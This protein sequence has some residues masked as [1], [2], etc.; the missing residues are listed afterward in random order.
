VKKNTPNP[1]RYFRFFCAFMLVFIMFP[2]LTSAASTG[3]TVFTPVNTDSY[4]S[5]S[6]SLN[7]PADKLPKESAV[8]TIKARDVDEERGEHDFVNVNGIRVGRLSG[9]NEQDSTTSFVID[10]TLIKAGINQIVIN[11]TDYGVPRNNFWNLKVYWGQLLLDGGAAEKADFSQLKIEN[12]DKNGAIVNV[13]VLAEV[14]AKQSGSYTIESNLIDPNGNNVG[15]KNT[16][17]S[18]TQG[19]TKVARPV[20]TYPLSAGSGIYTVNI[21]LFDISTGQQQSAQFIKFEH[22]QNFGPVTDKVA[23]TILFVTSSTPNGTYAKDESIIIEVKYDE[24]VYV[25]GNTKPRLL[26]ETGTVDQYADYFIGTGTD[27]LKFEYTV[28]D[29][30]VSSDLEYVNSNALELNGASIADSS[31]NNAVLTLPAIGSG[32][33]LSDL[34]DIKIMT[35]TAPTILGLQDVNLNEDTAVAVE[36]QVSDTE[37][38]V[39]DLTIT[40]T[41]DNELLLPTDQLIV[42]STE[43]GYSLPIQPLLNQYGSA[44]ITISAS[45]GLLSTTK[46]F[47]ITVN[48]VN[49]N[50]TLTLE[51]VTNIL[52]NEQGIVQISGTASDIEGDSLSVSATIGGV[53]KS[54]NVTNGLWTLTWNGSDLPN[55]TYSGFAVNVEDNLQGKNSTLYTG[56]ITVD[57]IPPTA[58]VSYSIEGPTNGDVIASI[59][60]SE[61]VTI[62]NNGG[63]KSYTFSQ[64]GSF[65][66]EFVDAAGNK[67]SVTAVVSSIDKIAPTLNVQ[68]NKPNIW[69][70]NHKLVEINASLLYSDDASGI[71]SVVLKSI[72]SNEPD[73][74]PSLVEDDQANDIQNSEFGEKDTSFHLRAE[75]SDKGTGRIYTI[76]YTVTDKAGNSTDVAVTVTIPHDQSKDKKK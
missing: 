47:T 39:S 61:E 18:L 7:V 69:P 44:N 11:I 43:N 65:T 10:P 41:S 14:T 26:L 27:T 60:P 49:D 8:L 28:Q 33:S 58:T 13:N 17:F 4:S 74:D 52:I 48:Q 53:T 19:Q 22:R 38:S 56:S 30:D 35:N 3:T 37:S 59:S 34:K 63:L 67:G 12:F 23:P 75:R 16:S 66:F 24:L 5:I 73:Y 25:S 76:I 45:D 42:G 68:L 2:S 62:T 15:I 71:A 32:N 64:N 29:K 20:F 50:P 46:T 1:I 70:P 31:N 57:K 9:E 54:A 72:T 6:F 40:V 51:N 55:G 21:F 36:F